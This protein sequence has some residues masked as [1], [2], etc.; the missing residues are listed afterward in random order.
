MGAIK[1]G[2][3]FNVE[4]EIIKTITLLDILQFSP[5]TAT[6][7]IAQINQDAVLRLINEFS[8]HM[9]MTVT[10]HND[11]KECPCG[12]QIENDG[13]FHEKLGDWFVLTLQ[14]SFPLFM[15][16]VCGLIV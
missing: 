3:V 14:K 13:S 12:Q 7:I 11:K 5:G 2:D 10:R 6:N 1:I 9:T 4:Q 8:D 16:K 15:S